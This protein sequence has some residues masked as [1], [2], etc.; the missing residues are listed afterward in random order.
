[1]EMSGKHY[2]P[3]ALLPGKNLVAISWEAGWD[4]EPVC[5]FWRKKSLASAGI[6]TRELYSP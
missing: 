1:M 2:A 3:A 5:T 4:P 6:R